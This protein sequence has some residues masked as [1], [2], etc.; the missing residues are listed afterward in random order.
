[1]GCSLLALIAFGLPRLV[2]AVLYLQ[3]YLTTAYQTTLWPVLGFIFMPYTTIA[4][5][6]AMNECGGLKDVGLLVVIIGVVLD[7]VSPTSTKFKLVEV[8]K[9]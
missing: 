7:L 9:K 6:Y 1:M 5:A 8:S 3:N 4:W 2:L